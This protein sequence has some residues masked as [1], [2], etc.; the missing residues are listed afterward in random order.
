MTFLAWLFVGLIAGMAA[1][2]VVNKTG[3]GLATDIGL[4][5]AG[6][7]TGGLLF[8]AVG[9]GTLDGLNLYSGLVAFVGAATVLVVHHAVIRRH[10]V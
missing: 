10:A 3:S 2:I 6:A 4:G 9:H 7:L 5:I 1:S 8:H